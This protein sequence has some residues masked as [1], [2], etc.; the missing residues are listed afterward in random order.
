MCVPCCTG[1]THPCS[2]PRIAQHPPRR[3]PPWCPTQFYPWNPRQSCRIR[4]PRASMLPAARRARW[5]PSASGAMQT[6][7]SCGPCS[8]A[9]PRR[10]HGRHKRR[11]SGTETLSESARLRARGPPCT[12]VSPASRRR[13]T[14]ADPRRQVRCQARRRQQ[15]PCASWPHAATPHQM[16]TMPWCTDGRV[17]HL[18]L[19]PLLLLRTDPAARNPTVSGS[20]VSGRVLRK[21]A[22]GGW[23]QNT[24]DGQKSSAHNRKQPLQ[25]RVALAE[26]LVVA[27]SAGSVRCIREIDED[28]PSRWAVCV[29][30][31]FNNL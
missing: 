6:P 29:S 13:R 18:L 23:A 15:V 16:M 26:L 30:Q 10:H 5:H 12:H 31:Y 22:C 24:M 3:T 27:R 25:S 4:R 20:R 7:Q 17:R 21:R 1:H 11:K 19:L 9:M 14:A 28:K 8:T 2:R